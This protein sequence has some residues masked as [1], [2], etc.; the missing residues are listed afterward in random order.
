MASTS[1]VVSN[2]RTQI[3][4]SLVN[5]CEYAMPVINGTDAKG[6]ETTWRARVRMIDSNTWDGT[7]PVADA[8][9]VAI[10]DS[11]FNNKPLANLYGWL[12]IDSGIIGGKVRAVVP[13]IIK[14]GKNL[15]RANATNVFC[16]TLREALSLHTK[17][18]KKSVNLAQTLDVDLY[19]PM[20]ASKLTTEIDDVTHYWVQRK[21]NGLRAMA[22]FSPA[23]GVIMYSRKRQLFPGLIINKQEL[24]AVGIPGGVY[25]DGEIYSHGTPLQV[26]SGAA[27]N[28]A[29]TFQFTYMV[30]DL[31]IPSR[32]NLLYSERLDILKSLKLNTSHVV[33]VETTHCKEAGKALELAKQYIADGY[34]GAMVRLD[35]EYICSYNDHHSKVL[36]KIKEVQDAEF[37]LIGFTSGRRGKA[38]RALMLK[39]QT[40]KGIEFDVTPALELAERERLFVTLQRVEDNGKTVFANKM[41]NHMMVVI[42]DEYSVDEVPQRARTQMLFR[43]KSDNYYSITV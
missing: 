7:L 36:L 26:L 30:Y 23:Q 35:R 25:L 14:A 6:H 29:S 19:P 31:Y 12:T 20:L 1:R 8:N 38:A 43:N 42:F 11:W 17:Q 27:R 16:Q 2:F 39:C 41:Q 21:Y 4:G 33:T 32:P 13:T 18:M 3:G 22:C 9:F 5:E 15:G 34:E 10:Q 24:A 28:S 37:K 40:S